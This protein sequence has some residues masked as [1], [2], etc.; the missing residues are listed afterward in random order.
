MEVT[1]EKEFLKFLFVGRRIEDFCM[2]EIGIDAVARSGADEAAI[3][4]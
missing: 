2:M 1:K 3:C 4:A